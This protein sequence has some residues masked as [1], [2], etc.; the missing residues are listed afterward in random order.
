MKKAYKSLIDIMI[1]N[2]TN[3]RLDE[4]A[5]KDKRIQSADRELNESLK[6]YAELSL[7]EESDEVVSRVLDAYGE[8]STAYAALA[9][10][11]GMKDAVKFLKEIRVI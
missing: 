9:Y 10:T 5:F 8:Q 7:P 6:H 11:Q 4:I 3:E 2:L 1:E